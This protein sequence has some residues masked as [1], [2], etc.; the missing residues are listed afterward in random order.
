[1][2]RYRRMVLMDR[3]IPFLAAFVGLVALGGAVLVQSSV[4]ERNQ[5]LADE[6]ELLRVDVDALAQQ[7]VEVAATAEGQAIAEANGTIEA[8]LALQERMNAME[9]EWASRP[10]V[11]PLAAEGAF[12]SAS[13]DGAPA[14]I[15]PS[16]PTE[17]CIP[18]GTRFMASTGDS[19]AICETPVVVKVS[20]ITDD[21]V[22]VDGAGVI[23]ETAFKPITGTNCRLTVLD[24]SGDGFAELRVSCN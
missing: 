15:D 6:L 22:M 23:T 12:F 9:A 24:A 4:G 17:D 7:V 11:A 1:M 20:A 2:R 3:F 10:A 16:W 5:R 18:M 21:N 8:L 14:E 13:T 19:L